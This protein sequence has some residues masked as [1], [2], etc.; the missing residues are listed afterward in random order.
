MFTTFLS[1]LIHNQKI[2]FSRLSSSVC[3]NYICDASVIEAYHKNEK[4]KSIIDRQEHQFYY[5]AD[6]Q[7]DLK[8][9]PVFK[10]FLDALHRPKDPYYLTGYVRLFPQSLL[11]IIS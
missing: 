9:P 3:K 8:A 10:V 2:I 7:K 1:R 4:L 5:Q 6:Q 11:N